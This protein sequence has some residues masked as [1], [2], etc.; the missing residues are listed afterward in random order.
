M[1]NKASK[2][3]TQEKED[4]YQNK[5]RKTPDVNNKHT[6]NKKKTHKPKPIPKISEFYNL[7]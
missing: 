7:V 1:I 5:E 6:G 2:E 3:L 4:Q